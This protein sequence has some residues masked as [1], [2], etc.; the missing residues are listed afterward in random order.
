ML[1]TYTAHGGKKVLARCARRPYM[2]HALGF[3]SLLSPLACG[4]VP[5]SAYTGMYTWYK[6]STVMYVPSHGPKDAFLLAHCTCAA[7]VLDWSAAAAMSYHVIKR[8]RIPKCWHKAKV[9]YGNPAKCSDALPPKYYGLH[10]CTSYG[11]RAHAGYLLHA[12]QRR[13]V[14]PPVDSYVRRYNLVRTTNPYGPANLY[15]TCTRGDGTWYIHA[16]LAHVAPHDWHFNTVVPSLR[17]TV[18]CLPA[19]CM[20]SRHK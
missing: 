18:C 13:Q 11:Y 3:D 17:I 10:C 2:H 20:C 9:H 19:T 4:P 15:L 8:T 6:V 7:V 14:G 16:C 1:S 5:H 12:H